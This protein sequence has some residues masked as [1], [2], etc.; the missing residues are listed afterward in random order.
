MASGLVTENSVYECVGHP[1]KNDVKTIINVLLNENFTVASQ[2]LST[3]KTTK[4]YALADIL[5][6]LHRYVHK[7]NYKIL[8]LLKYI[9]V[10][11]F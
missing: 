6:E 9:L 10:F 4:G 5:T 7:S 8:N 1:S 3:L 11:H 2:A